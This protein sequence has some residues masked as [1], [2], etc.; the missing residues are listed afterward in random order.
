MYQ[1]DTGRHLP[2]RMSSR[3]KRAAETEELSRCAERPSQEAVRRLPV[4]TGLAFKF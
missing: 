2:P 3:E 1:G 4:P